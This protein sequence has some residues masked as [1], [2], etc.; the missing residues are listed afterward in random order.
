MFSSLF[1]AAAVSVAEVVSIP[2]DLGN[3]PPIGFFSHSWRYPGTGTVERVCFTLRAPF[4]TVVSVRMVD[5]TGQTF[6]SRVAQGS[7]AWFPNEN[8]VDGQWELHFGGAKDGVF[9]HPLKAF[10]V[11]VHGGKSK[12]ETGSVFVKDVQ[13]HE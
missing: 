7:E 5:S 1:L 9:H 10:Q 6:Q 12:T 3:I 13:F 8:A 2:F 4:R 11:L